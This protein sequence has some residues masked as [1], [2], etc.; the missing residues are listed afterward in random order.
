M[1][2]KYMHHA[3]K[4]VRIFVV[5]S[6]LSKWNLITV[7]CKPLFWIKTSLFQPWLH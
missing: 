7:T 6:S 5:R 1:Y 3:S 2:V 4:V